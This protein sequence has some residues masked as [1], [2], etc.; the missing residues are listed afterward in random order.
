MISSL[1]LDG[2]EGD[3][4]VV[5]LEQVTYVILYNRVDTSVLGRGGEVFD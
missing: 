3:Q 2:K 5:A 4:W 1:R